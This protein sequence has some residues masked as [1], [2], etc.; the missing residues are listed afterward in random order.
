[1]K[2]KSSWWV[3]YETDIQTLYIRS[4]KRHKMLS[5]ATD[6]TLVREPQMG[7]LAAGQPAA[8][9]KAEQFS[10]LLAHSPVN[11]AQQHAFSEQHGVLPGLCTQFSAFI[12]VSFKNPLIPQ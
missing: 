9:L 1:M 7:V 4:L 10:D 2:E 8:K 5:K 11:T 3:K 12:H 6:A